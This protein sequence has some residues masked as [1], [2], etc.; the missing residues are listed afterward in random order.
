MSLKNM[1]LKDKVRLSEIQSI[2][3]DLLNDIKN[4]GLNDNYLEQL[5]INIKKSG[6]IVTY[7]Y[8]YL[9]KYK[10]IINKIL[11]NKNNININKIYK[12]KENN[13]IEIDDIYKYLPEIKHI[14]NKKIE[15]NIKNELLFEIYNNDNSIIKIKNNKF[16]ELL[17]KDENIIKHIYLTIN[18]NSN[19][20]QISNIMNTYNICN[21][22]KNNSNFKKEIDNMMFYN[23]K[24]DKLNTNNILYDS[25]NIVVKDITNYFNVKIFE[26]KIKH[27]NNIQLNLFIIFLEMIKLGKINIDFNLDN[28]YVD[29]LFNF[30]FLDYSNILELDKVNI[31]LFQKLIKIILN[32]NNDINNFLEKFV[33]SIIKNNKNND[34]QRIIS[35]IRSDLKNNNSSLIPIIK[36]IQYNVIKNINIFHYHV[37]TFLNIIIL[38]EN[39]TYLKNS[40]NIFSFF[41]SNI[42]K[43]KLKYLLN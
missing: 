25:Q 11:N 6:P 2:N 42:E 40:I 16:E 13:L 23:N 22:L 14:L 17:K 9:F 5:I 35:E 41:N 32:F 27:F 20:N 39:E 43:N 31:Q 30:C 1:K 26:N 21:H 7:I 28:L 19:N 34:S 4:N 36:I 37:S 15:K 24:I 3:I 8:I 33:I 18:E 38:I 10:N 29:N 12:I